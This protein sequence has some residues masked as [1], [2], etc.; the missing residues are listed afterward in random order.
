M[1][2]C[3]RNRNRSIR[4]RRYRA[5]NHRRCW[6][7]ASWCHGGEWAP[8]APFYVDVQ[9][10]TQS[11]LFGFSQEALTSMWTRSFNCVTVSLFWYA[12]RAIYRSHAVMERRGLSYVF[13]VEGQA[14]PAQIGMCRKELTDS[15]SVQPIWVISEWIDSTALTACGL[16]V[17]RPINSVCR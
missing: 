16:N 4:T 13:R 15:H 10:C 1:P 12:R 14:P 2:N 8:L 3:N 6:S 9:Y 5:S 17:Y 7:F 11:S